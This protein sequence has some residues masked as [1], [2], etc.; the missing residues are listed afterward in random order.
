[1]AFNSGFKGLSTVIMGIMRG[2]ILSVVK[3]VNNS[4]IF[5]TAQNTTYNIIPIVI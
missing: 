3:F 4:G 2:G 1:M 5:I